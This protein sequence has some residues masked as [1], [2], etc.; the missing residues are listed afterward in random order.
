[1]IVIGGTVCLAEGIIDH[2][3]FIIQVFHVC[4]SGKRQSS[5]LCPKGT[6]FN[7]KHRVCDWWYNVK[8]EDAAEFY[9][10]NLD[11]LL[12]ENNKGARNQLQINVP[13]PID[14]LTSGGFGILE[15]NNFL[16]SLGSDAVSSL[17]GGNS[18]SNFMLTD[19]SDKVNDDFEDSS[20][21]SSSAISFKTTSS[22]EADHNFDLSS[23]L[24][25]EVDHL[26]SKKSTMAKLEQLRS[27]Q[28]LSKD[29]E[30]MGFDTKDLKDLD[31]GD[32]SA[33][34]E[35]DFDLPISFSSSSNEDG[36]GSSVKKSKSKNKKDK[37]QLKSEVANDS[38]L[39]MSLCRLMN[40]CDSRP[41]PF[42]RPSASVPSYSS[43]TQRNRYQVQIPSLKLSSI[44][45]QRRSDDSEILDKGDTKRTGEK[46]AEEVAKIIEKSQ[47][48]DRDDIEDDDY[49]EVTGEEAEIL[50]QKIQEALLE[51]QSKEG[52][53][54]RLGLDQIAIESL[55]DLK[56]SESGKST[57]A[58]TSNQKDRN[59]KMFASKK[60]EDVVSVKSVRTDFKLSEDNMDRDSSGWRPAFKNS[61][62]ISKKT[63]MASDGWKPIGEPASRE[64]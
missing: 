19:R 29:L 50:G 43:K 27:L 56:T 41:G 45:S 59:P 39:G 54:A 17:V 35:P 1:M 58:A 8:C 48:T 60:Q 7:Q 5:F 55:M 22:K 31:F 34:L 24:S 63:N 28:E 49:V 42:Q 12:L 3:F 36:L 10:L 30:T 21:P 64:E 25:N 46:T 47:L 52:S 20:S 4:E 23:G 32:I 61:D 33:E 2:K 40:I 38:L 13:P 15:G 14:P 18:V 6:I 53:L 62:S 51:L 37:I 9:D 57:A 44:S 11:L 16:G 26:T